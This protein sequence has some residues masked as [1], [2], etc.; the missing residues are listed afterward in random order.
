MREPQG[1]C[2]L[3]RS[4][5]CWSITVDD[6]QRGAAGGRRQL[7]GQITPLVHRH[8]RPSEPMQGVA[9]RL[10]LLLSP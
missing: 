10:R 5:R 1:S 2:R 7:G 8:E 3:R 6:P 9:D 4:S